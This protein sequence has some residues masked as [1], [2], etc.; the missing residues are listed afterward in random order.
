MQLEYPPGIPDDVNFLLR[1]RFT[2][3]AK[4]IQTAVLEGV[5]N[6][7]PALALSGA[8]CYGA[9]P[10]D[11]LFF[12]VDS[13]ETQAR[14]LVPSGG[15]QQGDPVRGRAMFCLQPGLKRCR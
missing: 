3:N 10:A 14:S 2:Y 1:C 5:A 15:V 7:V 11:V 6:C 8:I 12:R 9:N 13:R 4:S